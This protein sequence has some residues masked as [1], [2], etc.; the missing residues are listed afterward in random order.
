M[1]SGGQKPQRL[2]ITGAPLPSFHWQSSWKADSLENAEFPPL[3]SFKPLYAFDLEI[4]RTLHRLRKVRHTITPDSSSS[5]S[6]W[7]FENSNFTTDKSNVFE[8]Q[9]AGSMENNDRT[10]KELATLDVVYQPWCIQ[11]PP[12][13]PAQSYELN[14]MVL[15]GRSSQALKGVS[16]G[17]FHDE[18]AGDTRGPHQ[19]ESVSILPGWGYKRLTVSVADFLQYLGRMFLEKFFSASRTATIRKEIYGIRQH[20]G[21]TLHKYWKRFNK[22]CATCPHHQIREQLLIQYFNEGLMMID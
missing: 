1:H 13:E 18:A 8:H 3:R 15:Q 21:E 12:L 14:F 22:L 7:N 17:L 6:I 5:N 9:V 19:D 11:C 4:K 16:C 10:L 2:A 20:S